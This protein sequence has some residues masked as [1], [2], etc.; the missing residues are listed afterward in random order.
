MQRNENSPSM[1]VWQFLPNS[2]RKTRLAAAICLAVS[3]I[4]CSTEAFAQSPNQTQARPVPDAQVEANVLRAFAGA[5]ELAAQD[6]H[7]HTVYGVVSL[8]GTVQN[9]A[10]QTRAENLAANA[11]GVKKVVDELQ[12]G[13]PVLAANGNHVSRTPLQAASEAAAATSGASAADPLPGSAP[14][15]TSVMN[16]P[17]RDQQQYQPQNTAGA[18]AQAGNS[19]GQ[20]PGAQPTPG[21]PA[22]GYPVQQGGPYG[23]RPVS[24][25]PGYAGVP[26]YGGASQ[27]AGRGRNPNYGPADQ[28]IYGGQIAGK[29]V[30]IPEGT[31]IRVRL[32]QDVSSNRSTPGSAFAAIV[33]TDVV[34]DGAV[35]IPRGAQ[36]QGT[37]VDATKA[38]ALKGRGDLT[39]A[40]QSVT[41]G[42]KVYPLVTRPWTHHSGDKTIE[43]VNKTAGFG[44]AGAVIGALAGGG[45]GAAVG[46]GIGAAAGL[47]SSATSGRGQVYVPAEAVLTFAL[48][49]PASVVTVSEQEMQ[50]LAY[51][52]VPNQ[53]PEAPRRRAFP[54]VYIAPVYYPGYYPGYYPRFYPGYY[55]PPYGYPPY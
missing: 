23:G 27:G 4:A 31:T 50:R 11:D 36:V 45:E 39:L 2:A 54:P 48:Q 42:G 46:G 34:A 22:T 55:P 33:Q 26:P 25:D 47:G 13:N 20:F 30:N 40:L 49:E 1:P 29:L 24:P 8:T 51:G 16:D 35:A 7:T 52:A 9:E 6:I 15:E 18:S 28:P 17:E 21:R 3:A 14:A 10:L 19:A 5:P 53:R 41:L 43:T 32:D 12:L 44:A 37:V 38:G